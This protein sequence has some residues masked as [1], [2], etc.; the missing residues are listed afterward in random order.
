MSQN[1]SVFMKRN[2]FFRFYFLFFVGRL[3]FFLLKEIAF[4][5]FSDEQYCNY[6]RREGEN[7]KEKLMDK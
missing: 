5:W 4:M 7:I 3:F 6:V 1:M 2:S